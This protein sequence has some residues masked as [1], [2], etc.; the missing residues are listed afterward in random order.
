MIFTT[1]TLVGLFLIGSIVQTRESRASGVYSTPVTVLNTTAN[2]AITLDAEQAARAPYS[3]SVNQ[4]CAPGLGTCQFLFSG[5]A[6]HRIVIQNVSGEIAV[7]PGTTNLPNIF[8]GTGN[9]GIGGNFWGFPPGPI[10][11]SGLGSILVNN[12]NQSVLAYIDQGGSAQVS[13][14]TN[15]TG[16]S[17]VTLTG[18]IQDCS[19]VPCPALQN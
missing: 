19:V 8:F 2:P 1:G 18:Y 14:Y 4:V 16:N 3:S 13:V 11:P 12:F 15:H 7:A 6:G 9:N 5:H 17:I 10:V